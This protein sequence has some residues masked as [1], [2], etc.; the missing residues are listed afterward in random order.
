[1]AHDMTSNYALNQIH[2]FESNSYN[3]IRRKK[4]GGRGGGVSPAFVIRENNQEAFNTS[5]LPSFLIFCCNT[6]IKK[7]SRK[8]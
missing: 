3:Q 4:K 6:T 7:N 1:M 5:E 8:K 2:A